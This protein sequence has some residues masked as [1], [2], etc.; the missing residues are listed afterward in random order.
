MGTNAKIELHAAE[1]EFYSALAELA[2]A[3][4]E[5]E[6][7]ND[8]LK[9]SFGVDTADL[10]RRVQYATDEVRRLTDY[11]RV[12]RIELNGAKVV[13]IISGDS[14][15]LVIG[16]LARVIGEKKHVVSD[17]SDDTPPFDASSLLHFAPG[18]LQPYL[19][20][21]WGSGSRLH[22]FDEVPW[23]TRLPFGALQ[24]TEIDPHREEEPGSDE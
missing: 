10:E 17:P 12:K 24:K 6:R 7:A 16:G 13:M 4:A 9:A 3:N 14:S 23:S 5:L 22:G 18:V 1:Y 11:V 8:A 2:K 19:D 20:P 15:P 21:A